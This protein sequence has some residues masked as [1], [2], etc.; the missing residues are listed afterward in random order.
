MR[1]FCSSADCC[2]H[3]CVSS[4]DCCDHYCVSSAVTSIVF[5]SVLRGWGEPN[6]IASKYME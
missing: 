2:D 3:Y 1:I 5:Y 6:H 4:A